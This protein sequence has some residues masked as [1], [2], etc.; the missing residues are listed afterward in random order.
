MLVTNGTRIVV[1]PYDADKLEEV[2][3]ALTKRAKDVL[4]VNKAK[5]ELL[6]TPYPHLTNASEFS[7]EELK[8][9]CVPDMDLQFRA[10]GTERVQLPTKKLK[11]IRHEFTT[12]E[13]V[14]LATTMAEAQAEKEKQES[15]KSQ[16]NKQYKER[17][18]GLEL[19][20]S[21]NGKK[22][23]EGYEI[24]T[25]E[26]NLHLDFENKVRVYTDINDGS[27]L[28]QEALETSDYQMRLELRENGEFEEPE[29]QENDTPEVDFEE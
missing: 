17:I 18:D 10:L 9:L 4:G 21:E 23:R 6:E 8:Q 19:T 25:R 28:H 29:A 12:D 27:I 15:E 1:L 20:I 14:T 3:K 5:F 22:Y 7:F 11:D 13:K 2:K 16:I 26:T 24:Q